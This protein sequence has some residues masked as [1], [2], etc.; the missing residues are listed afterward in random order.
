MSGLLIYDDWHLKDTLPRRYL[1]LFK[2]LQFKLPRVS[3]VI[4]WRKETYRT[5]V[6]KELYQVSFWLPV[7]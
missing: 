4:W 7:R 3:T 5:S 6:N 1:Q 2:Y